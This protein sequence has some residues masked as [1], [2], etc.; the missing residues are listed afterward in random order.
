VSYSRRLQFIEKKRIYIRVNSNS[1]RLEIS[2]DKSDGSESSIMG[3]GSIFKLNIKGYIF[4]SNN[5]FHFIRHYAGIL[6]EL[7]IIVRDHSCLSV[8]G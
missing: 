3:I 1:E 8:R 6:K 5:G 2:Q 7:T 4:S